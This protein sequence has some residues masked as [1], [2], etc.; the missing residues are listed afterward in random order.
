[1]VRAALSFTKDVSSPEIFRLWTAIHAIGSAAERRVWTDA[2]I[3]RLYPNLFVFMVGPPGV[4]KTSAMKPITALLRKAAACTISP[5]DMTKAGLLDALSQCL[6][7]VILDGEAYDYSYMACYI[8][9]MT[10][11]MAKYDSSLAGILTDLWDCGDLNEE[12]KRHGKGKT[13]PYPAISLLMGTATETLGDA[14]PNVQW[15]SGFM[16]RVILVY[17]DEAKPRP[18][19]FAKQTFSD[20]LA[21]EI[22]EGFKAIG[23]FKGPMAWTPEAQNLFN[24]FRTRKKETEIDHARLANYNTRRDLQ[25]GK[26]SMIAAL[27]ALRMEITEPDIHT[28]LGWLLPT[29]A[30]IPEIFHNMIHGEDAALLEE[31]CHHFR[32]RTAH[33]P[34]QPPELFQFFSKRTNVQRVDKLIEVA[35]NADY[36]AKVAGMALYFPLRRL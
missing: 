18:D 23:D 7:G 26:L 24:E 5:N 11:F 32:T 36:L 6:K 27:S 35:I 10:N 15:G 21:A 20:A 28:A 14:I 8:S 34:I 29:E 3:D 1:M 4:G 30:R 19:F 9:E 13:I 12:S 16:A 33:N 2:G 31:L 25:L 22:V 17:E